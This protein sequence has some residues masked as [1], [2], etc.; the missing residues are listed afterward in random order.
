MLMAQPCPWQIRC[1]VASCAVRRKACSPRWRKRKAGPVRIEVI[2]P[3]ELGTSETALWRTLQGEGQK[4]PYLTPDWAKMV[5]AVRA[6]ARVA[7]VSDGGG[8]CG[9]LG[10]QRPSRFAAMGLGAPIADYQGMVGPV[11]L[12][13]TAAELCRA[14]KVGRIDLS[15]VPAGQHF[16]AP[17]EAGADGSWLVDTSQGL[18]AYRAGLRARRGD[19]V[20]QQ[21]KK[22]RK[23]ARERG[24][25]AFKAN[26]KNPGHFQQMMDWKSAQLART[27]QPQIWKTPWISRVLNASFEA[28]SAYF[29]GVLF[30]LTIGDE[31]LAANY[32]LRGDGVLHD[33]IM[34]HNPAYEAYS[35]GVMLGRMCVEWAAENGIGEVD[36]GPGQYQYKR[37][38]STHQRDLAWGSAAG[39]FSAS[40]LVRR[41]AYAARAGLERAPQPRLAALPGKAMRRI[42]LLRGLAA[43]H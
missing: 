3:C 31:L 12:P 7:V 43:P 30:T 34:A 14:L 1:S 22:L 21:E 38:L 40:G 11:D 6:D 2:H 29:S 27:G 36:F 15:H 23:L 25:A 8:V 4:S 35:V 42:D 33:W 17:H 32:F 13:V 18:D 16:F 28:D 39:V 26:S 41:A 20:R 10:V 5:G 9:F 19:F 24:E 37:Q